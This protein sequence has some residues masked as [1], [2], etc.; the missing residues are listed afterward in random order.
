M[1]FQKEHDLA[2]E[3][4]LHHMGENLGFTYNVLTNFF[5][6]YVSVKIHNTSF[7]GDLEIKKLNKIFEEY[8]LA[9]EGWS[10]FKYRIEA[11]PT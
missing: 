1:C 6:C 2:E 7:N 5:A 11:A 10:K 4:F 8:D 3:Y 9:S